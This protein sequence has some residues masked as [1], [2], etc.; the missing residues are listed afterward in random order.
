L[1]NPH[2]NNWVDFTNFKLIGSLADFINSLENWLV[3][4]KGGLKERI[5]FNS[6][7]SG[8]NSN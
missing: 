7:D 5:I 6:L 8:F 1:H 4:A 2:F 3:I